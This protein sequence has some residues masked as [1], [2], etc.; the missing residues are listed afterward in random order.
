MEMLSTMTHEEN[1]TGTLRCPDVGWHEPNYPRSLRPSAPIRVP[2]PFAVTSALFRIGTVGWQNI[3]VATV[4]VVPQTVNLGTFD[5]V[6][7]K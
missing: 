2:R 4:A 7:V 6:A 3:S 1:C 5:L